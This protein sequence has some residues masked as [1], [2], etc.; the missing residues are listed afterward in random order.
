MSTIL[1][2]G[3]TGTLGTHVVR[4]LR[5]DGHH[6]RT[7]SR[8]PRPDDPDAHAVDLREGTGLDRALDGVD[9]VQHLASTPAGG[10]MAAAGNLIHAARAA[11]VHHLVYISIVGVDRVPLGYYKTKHTIEQALLASDLGVTI[12]RATQFHDLVRGLCDRLA[13]PFQDLAR[14]Y[15]D[16]RRLRRRLWPLRAP[17]RIFAAY[18]AGEHLT[19]EHRVG[20]TTFAEYLARDTTTATI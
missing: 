17:G 3:A 14:A 6:V 10:D 4:R 20:R 8:H 19:P 13:Q 15:L 11:N 12:V 5:E 1:V 9:T 2:T 7:L 16:S 18:R